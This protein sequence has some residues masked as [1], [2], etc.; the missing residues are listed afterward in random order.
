MSASDFT[1]SD[2]RAML[3]VQG[4]VWAEYTYHW[5]WMNVPYWAL[6]ALHDYLTG[7]E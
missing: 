7:K 4:P 6:N 3:R 2:Y 1:R 5:D